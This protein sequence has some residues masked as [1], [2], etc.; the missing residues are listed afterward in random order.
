[1]PRF[2]DPAL[3]WVLILS[4]LFL[5]A[6]D[7][8]EP[9]PSSH[10]LPDGSTYQGGM[11]DGLFHGEGRYESRDGDL[12]VGEFAAGEPVS[13]RHVTEQG[14]YS[15]HFRDW[16]YHGDGQLLMPDGSSYTGSF[17]AGELVLGEY[18]GA[19]GSR[20]QGEFQYWQYHGEG[21]LTQADGSRVE[22]RFAWGQPV[23]EV[24]FHPAGTDDETVPLAG[25]WQEGR[26]VAAGDKAPALQRSERVEQILAEDSQRLAAGIA[27]LAPPRQ[28]VM[29]VYLLAVGGD[30]TE[31]VFGRDIRMAR[32]AVTR[33]TGQPDR[34]LMLL[35]DR[36]Y[37]TLPLATRPN[38]AQALRALAQRLDPQEDLLVVHLVS[39]GDRD[40]NLL[41]RQPGLELPDLSPA[42]F[43][44]MLSPLADTRKVIVV[45]ACYSGHWVERLAAPD[46]LVMA[47]AR[48]DRTSFGC[49]DD[50]EMTWFTRSLY[51]DGGFDLA[52]ASALFE[53]T[54]DR[55]R[56]WEQ[57]QD[58]P[59]GEWSHP[60][61]AYGASL[62][63]W[64][65]TRWPL[66]DGGQ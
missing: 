20:Y 19:D 34:V 45:S 2:P 56:R 7:P 52:D 51:R 42:A 53:A 40:G 4:L 23:D 1:M 15:G 9:P 24:V 18:A 38:I 58:F 48:K 14:H 25:S 64:L 35:N 36:D 26:F 5:S 22:G 32:E 65:E 43:E 29:D 17:H 39:H 41:L 61:I 13:G 8:V 33:Q 37:E 44:G 54:A 28:G 6:C 21:A 12:Y 62:Q 31:S 49:G 63:E 66:L 11:A 30:G 55:I 10:Q 27:A 59:E 47:S 16:V 57:E 3:R 50:S 60:Q 46:T